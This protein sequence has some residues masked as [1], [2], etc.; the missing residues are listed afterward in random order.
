MCA[1]LMLSGPSNLSYNTTERDERRGGSGNTGI[2]QI[3][4][5]AFK[6]SWIATEADPSSLICGDSLVQLFD[7]LSPGGT[8]FRP[9]TA[10]GLRQRLELARYGRV[11]DIQ[12]TQGRRRR[13]SQILRFHIVCR[14]AGE[15]RTKRESKA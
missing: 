1:K 11:G 15:A 9:R 13:K 6:G 2:S 10:I 14:A 8:G 3:S 5:P 12:I 4:A 7:F